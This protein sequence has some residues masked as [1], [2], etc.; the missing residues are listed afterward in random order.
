MQSIIGRV[1]FVQG[2]DAC[3]QTEAILDD[4]WLSWRAAHVFYKPANAGQPLAL[5]FR[6]PHDTS[7]AALDEADEKLDVVRC[8]YRLVELD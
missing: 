3:V 1:F 8:K 7:D 4:D 5:K 6:Q 2:L